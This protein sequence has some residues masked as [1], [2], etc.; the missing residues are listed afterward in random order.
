MKGWKKV[1]AEIFIR[2]ENPIL[3]VSSSKANVYCSPTFFLK[4]SGKNKRKIKFNLGPRGRANS[5]HSRGREE[6]VERKEEKGRKKWISSASIAG[7]AAVP[8]AAQRGKTRR[9]TIAKIVAI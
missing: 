4:E 7:L 3:A 6:K 5:T 1:R 9:Q 2:V 8:S